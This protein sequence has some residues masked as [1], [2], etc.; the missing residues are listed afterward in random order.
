M[1]L[2]MALI[3]V[4]FL[5][6]AQEEDF[7]QFRQLT[8]QEAYDAQN[9]IHQ[10]KTQ[11]LINEGCS[12]GDM[13]E[14]DQGRVDEVGEVWGTFGNTMV[15][16]IGSMY[17]KFFGAMAMTGGGK[18]TFSGKGDTPTGDKFKNT[19][20]ATP[21]GG[22]APDKTYEKKET[23]LC[24][25]IPQA[26]ELVAM[27]MQQSAENQIQ[28]TQ[29]QSGANQQIAAFDQLISVHEAR[30]KSANVQFTGFA[31]TGGCYAT[32]ITVALASGQ[33]PKWDVYA[34]MGASGVLAT[35]YK[36]KANLHKD[37]E[38]KIRKIRD[39]LPGAG[40]CN[41]HTRTHC[42]CQEDTS[43]AV[44]PG[45]YSKYCVP[46]K[47]A[48]RDT[49]ATAMSCVND[50]LE[51]DPNCNCKTTNSCFDETLKLKANKLSLGNA[52]ASNLGG[53]GPLFGGVYDGA[54][55]SHLANSRNAFAKK[56][57]KNP[58]DAPKVKL[59]NAQEKAALE[60]NKM[61]LPPN[62]A[63]IGA[64]LPASATGTAKLMSGSPSLSAETLK[65]N[66]KAIGEV[67]TLS[68]AKGG[69]DRKKSKGTAVNPF[70]KYGFGKKKKEEVGGVDVMQFA[71]Q[72]Q[73][74]AEINKDD[75][76]SLFETISRRYRVSGA[77]KLE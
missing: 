27:A 60:L 68:F 76:A 56:T 20:P 40:D 41:P 5:C 24:A 31:A 6:L 44:D 28:Q 38:D 64:A 11:E 74:E 8:D 54:S 58:K 66:P 13:V 32:Y 46:Q 9:Y 49:P 73:A 53:T 25:F 70:G 43:A 47:Y 21:E 62:L 14:C 33:A 77:K 63:A 72:A 1:K 67:S 37:Y 22:A 29:P 10:G 15:P 52:F 50:K 51:E 57:M 55:L 18:L 2:T 19:T 12:Q 3:L 42:F 4:S 69:A 65:K 7:D 23:D 16:I 59:N 39:S 36:K 75:G 48:K 61:G 35:F 30:A 45:N 17:S 26:S 71:A 34:R